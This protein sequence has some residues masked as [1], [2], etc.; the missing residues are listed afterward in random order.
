MELTKREQLAYE[1]KNIKTI[2]TLDAGLLSDMWIETRYPGYAQLYPWS[3]SICWKK[4]SLS[5][6]IKGPILAKGCGRGSLSF[7]HAIS[8]NA[9]LHLDNISDIINKWVLSPGKPKY[10]PM[11]AMGM[12]G[13]ERI[14]PYSSDC[15]KM[16]PI[17]SEIRGILTKTF[18]KHL[19]MLLSED[20][21]GS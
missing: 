3:S 7:G 16:I 8:K 2:I 19:S 21:V 11:F 10:D 1:K 18:Q 13:V 15:F 6:V 14:E 20:E 17:Y 9:Y 4:S 12:L 5:A